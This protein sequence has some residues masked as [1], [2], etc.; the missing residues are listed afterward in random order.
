MTIHMYLSNE[1]RRELTMSYSL[2][3]CARLKELMV[4]LEQGDL[5]SVEDMH[6]TIAQAS[7]VLNR[8]RSILR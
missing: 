5:P 1:L 8:H 4:R 6:E 2:C 7:R 3:L